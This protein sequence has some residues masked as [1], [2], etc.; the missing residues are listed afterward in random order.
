MEHV[1][2]TNRD[3]ARAG[4]VVR[5]EKFDEEHRVGRRGH[6]QVETVIGPWAA[7]VNLEQTVR[8]GGRG[9]RRCTIVA[10]SGNFGS[11]WGQPHRADFIG[12]DPQRLRIGELPLAE[13]N[14]PLPEPLGA[15]AP[16]QTK[17]QRIGFRD[18]RRPQRKTTKQPPEESGSRSGAQVDGA[19]GSARTMPSD[20]LVRSSSIRSPQWV[21][22]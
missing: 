15:T 14:S 22:H 5:P 21:K 7:L 4:W 18:G 11:P 2:Q 6:R 13:C 1:G 3:P 10:D 16:F 12:F 19:S 20:V 17:P 8:R 9:A